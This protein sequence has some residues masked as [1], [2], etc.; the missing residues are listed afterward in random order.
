MKNSLMIKDAAQMIIDFQQLPAYKKITYTNFC[1]KFNKKFEGLFFAHHEKHEDEAYT[2]ARGWSASDYKWEDID[3]NIFEA[4]DFTQK[5]KP[6]Y[7]FQRAAT[8][9]AEVVD[10]IFISEEITNFNLA[11]KWVILDLKGIEYKTLKQKRREKKISDFKQKLK[12]NLKPAQIKIHSTYANF[13]KY[14][15]K[16]V[17]ELLPQDAEYFFNR[18]K[19]DRHYLDTILNNK[20]KAIENF[21]NRFGKIK[22][23]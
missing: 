8:Y 6:T 13:M 10:F 3:L 19:N 5:K 21:T 9:T 16:R 23:A 20:S 1:K 22:T 12:D 17:R 11:L 7:R 2:Y 18:R 15:E 4:R 14:F